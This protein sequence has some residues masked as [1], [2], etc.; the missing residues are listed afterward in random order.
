M[1]KKTKK[2]H[3]KL[4]VLYTCFAVLLG[5]FISVFSY[6]ITWD[7]ATSMY[8]EKAEQAAALAA[9]V[10][11]SE[12]IGSYVETGT[13]DEEYEALREQ[14][15]TMKKE[16]NLLYL[17]I[18][19]PGSDSFT[20]V[21]EAQVETDDPAYISS[22]GDVY[23]YTDLEYTYLIPD[24]E[25]KRPSQEVIIATESLFFGNGVSAWAPILDSEGEVV[26]MVE[27]DFA[28]DQVSDSIR[29]SLFAMLI[30][31][32]GLISLLILVQSFSIR[33]MVTVPL[34]KLT[35]RTLDFAADGTLT[36]F[37]DDIRTGDELQTLSEAFGQM[38]KDIVSYT[39]EKADLAAV[40]ERIATELDVAADIQRSMLPEQLAE[41]PD[42]RYLEIKGLLRSSDNMGGGFYD[43]FVIDSH[44]VG[45]ILCGMDSTGIPA[46][47]Q[48]IVTRT[49]MKSQFS[50]EKTLCEIMGEI[51]R[52]VYD[53]IDHRDPIFAFVG[54]LDTWEGHFSYI[55]AGYNPP[56]VM[57]RGERFELLAGE[58]YTPLGMER[59]V[60]YRELVLE[61]R[62]GDRLLFYSDG[63]TDAR[64]RSG[65]TYGAER[66]RAGL[67]EMRGMEY[68]PGV[69][70]D[71][72]V[73]AVEEFT[74]KTIPD[75][76]LVLL[77]LEYKR[78]NRE[79]AT[80]ELTPEMERSGQLREFLKEQL[81]S[82]QI[83]GKNYARF[84]VC[85]EEMFAIA[86][87]YTVG[88]RIEVECV[89]PDAEKM[90]LQFSAVMCG[91]PLRDEQDS[92]QNAVAFIQKHVDRLT[93]EVQRGRQVLI[94]E[95]SM[96][97]S[98]VDR[99][100]V[101]ASVAR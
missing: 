79:H 48:M 60:I 30:G 96:T 81:T 44:R 71:G 17:Y 45:V 54:I 67:S 1:K 57:R 29:N 38:S 58:A 16:L 82:N 47:M 2:L 88:S 32:I 68:H 23:E 70:M 91:D 52:Q 39:N 63:V 100:P 33:K 84:L 76:D 3:I 12:R 56:V 92:V 66:L 95:K 13:V 18:F 99:T 21:V 41:F 80:L 87:R 19:V 26:A 8:S 14:L 10:V 72:V 24:V 50:G 15:N 34:R 61:L 78:G 75:A 28:L 4:T 74:G 40:Q 7:L 90:I 46:A 31:Y 36:E 59:N 73:K 5:L 53:A 64:S 93:S 97:K 35:D 77:A 9:T 25:A 94:M 86:C 42:K 20:Y 49:I 89:V 27:A 11:D 6:K 83:T 51:N 62:Q 85:A 65:E 101:G 69:L 43:Y 98:A 22:L 37:K 55:N